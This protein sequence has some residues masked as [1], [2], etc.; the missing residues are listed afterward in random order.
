MSYRVLI[1]TPHP[2][3]PLLRQ[4]PGQAAHMF[5]PNKSP[6]CNRH[7]ATWD[8][9]TFIVD[10]EPD[11]VDAWVVLEDVNGPQRTKV[12]PQ[13]T[14]LL[15]GEPPSMR[16]YRTS[17][18]QQFSQVITC[19]AALANDNIRQ[20]AI[21]LAPQGLPWHIGIDR[22]RNDHV[23]YAYD[24]FATAPTP[25]KTGLLSVV[26]SNKTITRDH[27]ARL[28]F[29]QVLKSHFGSDLAVF[30]RGFQEIGDKW[31]AIAPF[32][33]HVVLEND[34]VAHYFSEKLTDCFLAQTYPIYYGC[35]NVAQYFPQNGFSAIDIHQ[36]DQAIATIQKAIDA[37]LDLERGEAVRQSRDLV[38]NEYNLFSIIRNYFS[39]RLQPGRPLEQTLYPRRHKW[40]LQWAKL[41]RL[42]RRL[43][44]AA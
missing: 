35:P 31:D 6:G 4:L 43:V 24:D 15:T 40:S 28:E 17:Y 38:L 8:D 23:S 16:R 9:W 27:R 12:P 25:S 21:Q 26:C 14:L 10:Q 32:R 13:N 11:E 29:V 19:H 34:S 41:Q 7:V 39:Q 44:Q 42:H 18:L 30:G 36:P 1:S 22:M 2:D 37:Q 20:P 3:W 33:F 5:A